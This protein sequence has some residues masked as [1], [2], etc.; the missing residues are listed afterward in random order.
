MAH[1]PV[2][3]D[4][5]YRSLR[6]LGLGA[7]MSLLIAVALLLGI[8]I[9]VGFGYHV[10]ALAITLL[11]LA[12]LTVLRWLERRAIAPVRGPDPE[13]PRRANPRDGDR[14]A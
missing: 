7:R 6:S 9:T 12:V 2:R 3:P 13:H 1:L 14:K 10:L 5:G 8:G 11:A 4:S